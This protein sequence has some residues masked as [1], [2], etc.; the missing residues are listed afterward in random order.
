[1]LKMSNFPEHWIN[2]SVIQDQDSENSSD[3][4][5]DVDEDLDYDFY[6]RNEHLSV[7]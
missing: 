2:M 1:M 3:S 6:P 5:P 4:I 7:K